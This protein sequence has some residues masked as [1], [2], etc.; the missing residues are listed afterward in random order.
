MD[1]T[2]NRTVSSVVPSLKERAALSIS[3]AQI[4]ATPPNRA[5]QL[6]R[7]MMIS[8]VPSMQNGRLDPT[9]FLIP[10]N[11]QKQAEVSPFPSL[12]KSPFRPANLISKEP[13]LTENALFR[14]PSEGTALR[15]PLTSNDNQRRQSDIHARIRRRS[16]PSFLRKP[17]H[18]SPHNG[19]AGR[20]SSI[21]EELQKSVPN[22][23]I[24]FPMFPPSPSI[25]SSSQ[26]ALLAPI[27][28]IPTHL[29]TPLNDTDQLVADMSDFSLAPNPVHMYSSPVKVLSTQ[30][31]DP[32]FVQQSFRT[33]SSPGVVIPSLEISWCKDSAAHSSPIKPTVASSSDPLNL[34][35]PKYYSG[36]GDT[37]KPN[38]LSHPKA[39]ANRSGRLSVIPATNDMFGSPRLKLPTKVYGKKGSKSVQFALAVSESEVEGDSNSKVGK[40]SKKVRTRRPFPKSPPRINPMELS[41]DELLMH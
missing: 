3:N 36:D 34:L 21:L 15:R 4:P 31:S 13:N 5:S 11:R 37:M 41:D 18:F 20:K 35:H 16:R 40:E 17:T 26:A 27:P 25:M 38:R 22:T 10:R 12:L 23:P 30:G 19:K 2:S 7:A 9:S 6:P 1:F 39:I 8:P 24:S 33:Q 14:R 32:L 29:D 28:R